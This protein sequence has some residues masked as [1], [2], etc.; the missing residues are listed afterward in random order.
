MRKRKKEKEILLLIL[1]YLGVWSDLMSQDYYA[2]DCEYEDGDIDEYQYD[3][4]EDLK[5]S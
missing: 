2:E 3:Q 4:D 1:S 5:L